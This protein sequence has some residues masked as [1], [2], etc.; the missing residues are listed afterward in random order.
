MGNEE[1]Q[2]LLWAYAFSLAKRLSTAEQGVTGVWCRGVGGGRGC[3]YRIENR[4]A[5]EIFTSSN[6]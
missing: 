1:Q 5:W 2:Q 4:G 3:G 6:C